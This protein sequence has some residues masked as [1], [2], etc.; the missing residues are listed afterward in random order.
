MQL[1]YAL[2]PKEQAA[3][4]ILPAKHALDG[5]KTLFENGGIEERL[6]ASLG[7]FPTPRIGVN[8]GVIPRLKIALRFLRQS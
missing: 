5:I 2:K 4:L 6:A 8:V 7:R 3:K 1:T